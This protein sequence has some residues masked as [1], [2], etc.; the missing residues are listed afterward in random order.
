MSAGV[1]TAQ[2]EDELI[3]F[4]SMT[5]WFS[6]GVECHGPKSVDMGH[7]WSVLINQFGLISFVRVVCLGAK[8]P[9]SI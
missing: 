7:S 4:E 5:S 9:L 6:R 1:S 8:P 3:F 2:L